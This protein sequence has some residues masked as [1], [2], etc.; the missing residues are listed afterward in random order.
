VRVLECRAR[1]LI[2]LFSLC[3]DLLLM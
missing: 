3:W 1:R 2:Y